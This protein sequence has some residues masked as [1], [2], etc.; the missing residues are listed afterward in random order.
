MSIAAS[1]LSHQSPADETSA[2]ILL[3]AATSRNGLARLLHAAGVTVVTSCFL[4]PMIA[5]GWFVTV[6][7]TGAWINLISRGLTARQAPVARRWS[8]VSLISANVINSAMTA[9]VS[10]ALWSE[11]S[12]ASRLCG[13]LILAIN[14]TYVLLRFSSNATMLSLLLSIPALALV[15]IA[16]SSI[17]A[18]T[19][20]SLRSIAALAAIAICLVNFFTGSRRQIIADRDKLVEARRRASEGERAAE[21]A[22]VAKSQFLATMSHEI[23]TPLN[24]VLGMTQAIMADE[25]SER[26]R[27]RLDI[28][29]QSGQSLLAILNDI[30]DLSKIE[31]G[32]LELEVIP[33][34]LEEVARSAHAAFTGLAA[35]KGLFFRLETE[36]TEGSYL[37]DPVRLRQIIYNMIS[38]AL[39]FTE[40]GEVCVAVRWREGVLSITVSDTG[41]GIEPNTMD[42]LF[43]KFTQ[44]DASTTRR[45]GGTGL[46]LAIC[47]HLAEAMDGSISVQSQPGKGSRF[48]LTAPLRQVDEAPAAAARGAASAT[49]SNALDRP[50]RILAAEDNPTNQLVLKTLLNQAGIQ[51]VI[52][53]DGLAAVQAWQR[54]DWD[55]ILMD[56]HMPEMDGPGATRRIRE[57]EQQ[58]GGRR[59]PILALTANAMS[60]QVAQYMAMGMDGHIAKPVEISAL[61]AS[62]ERALANTGESQAVCAVA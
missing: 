26:Q 61:F 3:L 48:T 45:F 35:K 6:S 14:C 41:V 43:H 58:R 25:L 8:E 23:R 24:G 54:E 56:V 34:D 37:G 19:N 50:V 42:R 27:D 15:Y 5:A 17:T 28:V 59:T 7:A 10:A 21:A 2:Q 16:G 47:R 18:Q 20:D 1:K 55:V 30:L 60:D 33:F 12:P 49:S 52:V 9:F 39:K 31:A 29:R 11:P 36:G 13:V 57:L 4:G 44:A 46:G 32:K 22:N 40:A 51:P 62:I 38:N 53:G